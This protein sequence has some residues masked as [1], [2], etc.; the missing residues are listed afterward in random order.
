M[1][2]FNSLTVLCSTCMLMFYPFGAKA[3]LPLENSNE[4]PTNVI[5]FIGDGMSLAQWQ[6]G[7]IMN[8]APLNIEKMPSVGIVQTHSL[9]HFNGDGPSH[10]TAIA[11]G[12]NSHQGA[13]GVDAGDAP[14][15]SIVEYA[16]ENG[17]ATGIVSANTLFEGSLAPFV[18]HV[19]SRMQTEAIAEAYVERKPDVFIGGGL[20]FFLN[21]K[22][23]RD[24]LAELRADGYQ[25]AESFEKMQNVRS[26]KL[27]GFTAEGSLSDLLQER[28]TMFTESVALALDL[29]GQHPKGFF[30]L[31]G[32]MFIDRA[33]HAGDT[34]RVGR[35]TIEF[36]K[37]I[38][39]ALDFAE[40]NGNTLVI[41]VGGPEASGMTLVDGNLPQRRAE[42]K[43]TMPGMI[44]T[45][46]MVPVFS[47]GPG[48]EDFQGIMKNTD[49]F[50]KIKERML[51]VPTLTTNHR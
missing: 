35:E 18:A 2:C 10:G 15:K 49:L 28:G 31:A 9:T 27:A 13:V 32:D 39:K 48:S 47:Y 44:H 4:K 40:N 25:V 11:T 45:G 21:R 17:I 14:V 16:S 33:S 26:G 1:K 51:N 20:K 22:D 34:E 5:L 7:M 23:G 38:G 43:W 3:G 12:V 46:T 24:L 50:F 30:L 19:K 41:V 36:D 37:A 8:D 6:T 29:L 42:A